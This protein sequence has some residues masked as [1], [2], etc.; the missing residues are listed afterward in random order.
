MKYKSFTLKEIAEIQTNNFKLI[1]FI[2]FKNINCLE[3][4]F[5]KSANN[6][7]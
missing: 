3:L 2:I 6:L 5:I 4:L 7:S 1:F